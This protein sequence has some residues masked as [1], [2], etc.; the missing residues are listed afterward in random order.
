MEAIRSA[1]GFGGIVILAV[2]FFVM[3]I[4]SKAKKAGGS[5]AIERAEKR[6]SEAGATDGGAASLDSIL[7][8]I[9][10]VKRQKEHGPMA[11]RPAPQARQAPRLKP[12]APPPRQ[13]DV[14]QDDRGPL[15]R[16]SRTQLESAEE[17][18]DRTSL[19]EEG[20]LAGERR[21]ENV[22]VFTARP[23]RV[24]QNRD[25]E[26]EAIAQRRIKSAQDRNRSH[27]AVDRE[28]FDRSVRKA[29]EPVVP[30]QRV[31]V[32]G[33]RDAFVWREILGPPKSL[34]DE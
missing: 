17:V 23:E 4:I 34:Q 15:G 29:D 6:V 5:S 14:V 25:E 11:G 30:R 1:D 2:L 19:E 22:E 31:T 21:L 8:Q 16:I 24:V 12:K 27:A 10:A 33:L 18:E 28:K 3:N 32:Q 20:R 26:A 13:R 7:R 9:E